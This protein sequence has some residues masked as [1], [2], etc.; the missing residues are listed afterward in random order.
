MSHQSF[1]PPESFNGSTEK[2]GNRQ[3]G[4][5]TEEEALKAF[6]DGIKVQSICEINRGHPP[7]PYDAFSLHV[8]GEQVEIWGQKEFE[9][10]NCHFVFAGKKE[11]ASWN[12]GILVTKIAASVDQ[13][14]PKLRFQ[15][16]VFNRTL[17]SW[18]RESFCE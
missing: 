9:M 6:S 7:L 3:G 12:N 17:I 8:N 14:S 2:S 15:C 13:W 1:D 18:S 10:I 5:L 16:K 4:F 11:N